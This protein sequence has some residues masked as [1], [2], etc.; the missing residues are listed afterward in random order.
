MPHIDAPAASQAFTANGDGDGYVDVSS[1]AGF[2][3][4]AIAYIAR[5]N[6]QERVIITELVGTTQVGVRKIG[7]DNK[8]QGAIQRYGGRSDL[9]GYTTAL[10]SRL[11][12]PAQLV[13]VEIQFGKPTGL[14]V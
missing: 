10:S 5:N 6:L 11:E 3:V 13:K 4:G 12:M 14:S 9:T 7:D 1:N 8:Q 2:Y